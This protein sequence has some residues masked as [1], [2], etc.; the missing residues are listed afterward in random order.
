MLATEVP[1]EE[2]VVPLVARRYVSRFFRG[3]LAECGRVFFWGGTPVWGSLNIVVMLVAKDDG[4]QGC[5]CCLVEV[6]A[7]C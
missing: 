1:A 6:S 5:P 3:W 4:L 7:M 2:S